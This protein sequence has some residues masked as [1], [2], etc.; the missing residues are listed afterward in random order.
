M[1]T[2]AIK[3]IKT[4]LDDLPFG[5]KPDVPLSGRKL[6][7][8]SLP[9][10]VRHRMLYGDIVKIAWPSFLE[11]VL[12]QLT[13]MADQIM[14]G[15][16]PGEIGV[17]ALSA[18]GITTLPKFLMMTMVSAL[19][20]GSTAVIARYRG[21]GERDRV[22]Q[23]LRQTLVL[24]LLLSV[25]FMTIGLVFAPLLLRM[26]GSD[27]IS[28]EA[29]AFGLS[30]FRIQ[31]YGFVPLC[32]TFTITASLRG[33]GDTRHPLFYNTLANI[34]NVVFNYLLIFGHFGFPRMEV[35]G[36][37]LA[38][39]IGQL[40]AF[41][42]AVVLILNRNRY[43]YFDW[44]TPYRFD[45]VIVKNIVK[46]GLPSMVEQL[47]MRAGLIIYTRTVTGLGDTA[48]ATH[49]IC[50][51]IQSMS[52]M[53]GQAFSNA[54]TTLMGQSLGKHRYDMAVHYSRDTRNIGAAVSVLIGLALIIFGQDVVRLYNSTPEIVRLGGV[55]LIM[56]GVTQP[57]QACQF[58][59][60]GAL[61]GAGDTKFSALTM[62]I[63]VLLLRSSLAVLFV[64]AL[65]TGL[66][67]AWY[68]LVVDQ[69]VRS[70]LIYFY[71]RSG[72][73]SR[74]RLKDV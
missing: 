15:H 5:E 70:L 32:I 62:L 17:Q 11:L 68:A 30:Y 55:L 63:T 54:A 58:I 4:T 27:G 73:W 22:N 34:I 14:V 61:R 46:I 39:V 53:T 9:E 35:A 47:I 66:I 23:V 31:M 7:R 69:L 49:Q 51:N 60:S 6:R 71:Y 24:N 50:M 38:T 52:F 45:P 65:H 64:R 56:V 3:K 20:V 72:R 42:I 13:S 57:L 18:V 48:Y 29:Y 37:S 21:R 43:L 26:M 16:L 40:A 36:A 1:E 41:S 59:L 44:K 74:V 19:N 67:G 28:P 12:T 10:G 25:L 2:N 8:L 33:I